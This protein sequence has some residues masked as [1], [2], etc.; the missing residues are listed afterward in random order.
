MA[1]EPKASSSKVKSRTLAY[2]AKVKAPKAPK[3]PKAD[4]AAR[5]GAGMGAVM[6][7]D[8]AVTVRGLVPYLLVGLVVFALLVPV[9]TVAF[10]D[11]S[12]LNLSYT[13]DQL[14]FRFYL[15]DVAPLVLAAAVLFGAV[16]AFGLFRFV[17]IRSESTARFSLSLSRGRLF[18]VRAVCGLVTVALAIGIPLAVSLVLNVWALGDWSGLYEHWAYVACGLLLAAAV[19]FV[20]MA[21]A[22]ALSGTTA[23]ALLAYVAIIG[24]VSAAAFTADQLATSLLVGNPFGETLL[25]TS[26]EVAPSLFALASPVNPLF[27]FAT[28]VT[29]SQTFSVLHPVYEPGP[30]DWSLVALWTILLVVLLVCAAMLFV[31]RKAEIAGLAN[32]NKVL[33]AFIAVVIALAV[34]AA[35]V[36]VLASLSTAV[37]VVGAVVAY[38]VVCLLLLAGPLT[39]G[40]RN[41]RA[42]ALV[43]GISTVCVAAVAIVVA[44]GALG[45]AGAVPDAAKVSH[46]RV[47][48]VG[49]PDFVPAKMASASAGTGDYY[50]SVTLDF[51]SDEAIDAVIAAHGELARAG[52]LA[53]DVTQADFGQ[54]V[55]PYDLVFDYTLTDG[56]TMT[57]YYDRAPYAVIAQ[58]LALDAADETRLRGQAV[59]KGDT[60]ALPEGER[61]AAASSLAA[62]AFST[63]R[64]FICDSLYAYPRELTLSA[65][66]RT[67]LLS[68]LA[69]DVAAQ[70]VE[71]R[72]YPDGP[73]LGMLMF[74]QNGETDSKSF[75]YR[76]ENSVVY[77]TAEYE[78][79][80]AWLAEN[81][82]MGYLDVDASVIEEL[83][84]QRFDPHSA[85]EA[86]LS[87][88]GIV[89]KGYRDVNPSRFIVTQDWG[90]LYATTDRAEIEEVLPLLRNTYALDHG[91]YLVRA[92]LAGLQEYCYFY[93]PASDTSTRLQELIG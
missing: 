81:D 51:E 82:L 52:A 14:K 83:A 48:Y 86:T 73:A 19:S 27:F 2:E 75:A 90:A 79:T 22:L 35:V 50:Y 68:A 32:T 23:E 46:V 12:I 72:Y 34:F 33:T 21:G 63:G 28:G 39:R 62:Q 71:D 88:L 56:T 77:L 74:S 24:C 42:T 20:V 13:H 1:L 11:Q 47:S 55:V 10:F 26:N 93:L 57:R 45:F 8:A 41:M 58:L 3:A 85:N 92:K 87:P 65:S 78:N 16:V 7:H 84:F 25:G 29:E 38:A 15:D 66:E 64:V 70:D 54:T 9:S 31:R 61:S 40:S 91:G 4:R 59:V 37:G 67:S 18:A 5:A 43:T 60:G 44:T 49:A 69:A 80:L 53:M 17:V 36:A 30:C 89:F 6:A 76:L